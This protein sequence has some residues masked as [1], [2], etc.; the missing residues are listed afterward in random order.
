MSTIYSFLQ[1]R[2]MHENHHGF[3][4]IFTAYVLSGLMLLLG[5]DVFY[6]IK[7]SAKGVSMDAEEE[8]NE[9]VVKDIKNLQYAGFT[10][11]A[12][13]EDLVNP[14]GLGEGTNQLRDK[15]QVKKEIENTSTSGDTIWLFGRTMEGKDFDIIMEQ[16]SAKT[17]LTAGAA[18]GNTVMNLSVTEKVDKAGT[19]L[20]T[21]G[22]GNTKAK[23]KE[24]EASSS[25]SVMDVTKE[26]IKMLERIVEAE[27]SGEDMKGKILIAN[28]I[29]NRIEDE[30]FPDTIEDVIFQKVNGDY[31]FSPIS[32]ERY[33][34]VTVSK[35]TKKAVQRALEGEDYSEGA[36]YFVAKKRTKSSS[37][38]WF[39]QRLEWLF[40]HGGH[41]FYKNK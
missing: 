27:A 32:D 6:N 5:S 2:K 9:I 15:I 19:A 3:I 37:A 24:V 14:Y 4:M 23:S 16:L 34:S 7:S 40:K 22:K 18:S 12:E 31:Q 36:L 26:E 30:E 13:F 21:S 33:W 10:S 8:T 39:D 38:K 29:F 1:K 35:D 17:S 25:T 41:D 11:R 20:K 28:V